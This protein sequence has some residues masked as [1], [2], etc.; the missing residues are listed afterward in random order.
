MKRVL[1]AITVLC[2][3][4]CSQLTV[5]MGG[6]VVEETNQLVAANRYDRAF[7]LH[8]SLKPE[9]QRETRVQQSKKKL[10]VSAKKFEDATLKKARRFKN[11]GKWPEAL[12]L[13]EQALSG[14]E[15]SGRLQFEYKSLLSARNELRDR[16]WLA[17]SVERAKNLQRL[18]ADLQDLLL[19]DSAYSDAKKLHKN[20]RSEAR[21]LARY[22]ADAAEGKQREGLYGEALRLY[23]LANELS[24]RD[25]WNQQVANL[26]KFHAQDEASKKKSNAKRRQ[27]RLLS[28]REVFQEY[29]RDDQLLK[30]KLQ[31]RKLESIDSNTELL[32]RMHD[33]LD[34]HIARKVQQLT[35]QGKKYYANQQ[36]EQAIKN[37][38]EALVLDPSN[39]EL[40]TLYRRAKTFKAYYEKLQSTE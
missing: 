31:L 34:K 7:A 21:D 4:A 3:S 17:L 37:W 35:E 12:G 39:E 28:E 11:G 36:L 23:R 30:A 29:L 26:E 14:Y 9:M 8:E 18:N 33:S 15:S 13:I 24:D 16:Q 32:K 5:M 20:Y 6:D 25:K 1:A 10:Q 2:L 40:A 19:V 38:E 27:Q 22:L